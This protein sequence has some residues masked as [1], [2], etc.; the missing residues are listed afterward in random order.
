MCPAQDCRLN[1]LYLESSS[2]ES[3]EV[4]IIFMLLNLFFK[5]RLKEQ[6]HPAN[7]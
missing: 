7:K 3:Y 1:L 2:Q 4:V 6:G 5:W